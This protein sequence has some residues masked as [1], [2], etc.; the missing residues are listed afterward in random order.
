VALPNSSAA[1]PLLT[2]HRDRVGTGATPSHSRN[3]QVGHDNE[4]LDRLA[5]RLAERLAVRLG[6]LMP[7]QPEVLVDA[8]EI[9]RIHGKTRS[10]VYQH[11]GELGAIRLGTGP[12]PR[13]G[14]SL[15]RV[16]AFLAAA[17]HV[18]QPERAAPGKPRRQRS[19][20]RRPAALLPVRMRAR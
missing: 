10:W 11:A 2:L 6:A 5:D 1:D 7:E 12:R 19:A 16:A 17:Q 9:A 13:L 20:G 8:V 18:E 3:E 14:F 15:A 4:A